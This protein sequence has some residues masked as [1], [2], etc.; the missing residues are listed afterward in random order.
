M[1]KVGK[2]WRV[3]PRQADLSR[4][5]GQDLGISP[6][7]AQVLI[8]RGILDLESARHF[9]HGGVEGLGDPWLMAG[10][11]PAVDR[12]KTALDRREKITIYGDYDVDGI[13]ASALVYRVLRQLGAT[14][15]YY[16]PER[17]SEGYGLND[18]A[19]E[20]LA[21]SG[22]SLVITVDCGISA[23]AEVT[24]MAERLDIIITDHHQ[25]PELLP[26]ARAIINPKQPDCRYPE[27]RLAGVGV[28]F[29]LCQALWL[30]LGQPADRLM[31]YLDLVAV[32][33]IAD[34]VPLN[35]ENRILVK[36][37][38]KTLGAT[39][40]I[41]LAALI[42]V[43]GLAADGIDAGK[44]GYTLAPRL[45]AAGRMSHATAGVDLLVTADTDRAAE[46]AA[47]LNEENIKRQAMEKELLVAAEKTL[48]EY[49]LSKQKVLVLAGEDWHPGVIG[50][51][52]SRLV[53]KHY[54]P[55]AMISVRDGIG[56]GS[57]RSIPGFDM[58]QA[59]T[60]CADLLIQFGGHQMAAG[61]TIEAAK[62][63]EFRARL[64]SLAGEWL[65]DEDYVPV[66]AIDS[67]LA[68]A[69]VDAA[70]IEQLACLAPHGMGNPNPVFVS[71][72][73]A[74]TD[75]RPLGQ[76]GRHCRLRVRQNGS[77]GEVLAWNLAG[78]AAGLESSD[79]IDLAFIPEFN[80]WQGRRSIQ[81][82]ARDLRSRALLPPGLTLTDARGEADKAAYI[83]ALAAGGHRVFVYANDRRH[84]VKLARQ[85]QT[86]L[87]GRSGVCHRGL[88]PG[89][90]NRGQENW[91]AGSLQIL[92]STQPVPAV[93]ALAEQ[94]VLYQPP[95][96][97]AIFI[98]LSRSLS[99]QAQ[100]VNLHFLYGAAD[101]ALAA[102][103]LEATFP[104][105]TMVGRVYL[106]LKGW[107]A[108]EDGSRIS[109][110]ALGQKVGTA[111]GAA[112]N[113]VGAET[114]LRILEELCLVSRSDSEGGRIRLLPEPPEK[115]DIAKSPLFRECSRSRDDFSR[116]NREVMQ[117]TVAKLWKKATVNADGRE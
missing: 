12:I 104:D 10:M 107:I 81:L 87:P 79:N 83:A 90:I 85:L 2:K 60:R 24:K 44:V 15:E 88:P 114:A 6:V 28:A 36:L 66:L 64:G 40:N 52:A 112:L 78:E 19:L 21:A 7:V 91:Q 99:P 5:F 73:L 32:G 111:Y 70:F 30:D 39:T 71:E 14:V 47:E 58:Y 57:C 20:G 95:L 53:E 49:D 106:V 96:S 94:I 26:P 55:V 37:G 43:S 9:L 50:I 103:V 27:K 46:L 97:R 45:N 82:R 4:T 63:D 100:P 117:V 67:E 61:L 33:T 35:G 56:K 68:L 89:R 22:T 34:I 98:R 3:S 108:K 65:S 25:P 23:V 62:I 115:L 93:L 77:V 101:D 86:I 11:K 31:E 29:K 69:E 1:F 18:T 17:Q 13:T 102:G 48:A 54:R 75:K 113:E 110:A 41:G 80:D 38:L 74:V 8:N 92:I 84:A 51:V 116:W 105:R 109:V 16:I 59:L 42:K 72:S 76:D